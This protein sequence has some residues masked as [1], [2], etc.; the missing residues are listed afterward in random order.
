MGRPFDAGQDL[1]A[2]GRDHAEA[3][4]AGRRFFGV[5]QGETADG[6]PRGGPTFKTAAHNIFDHDI[7][8]DV[9][10]QTGITIDGERYV[11]TARDP[12]G[13]GTV[14]LTLTEA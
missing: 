14:L 12:D 4:I 10:H 3:R 6:N 1:D 9:K 7:G 8:R 13:R 5:F 2:I 11:I